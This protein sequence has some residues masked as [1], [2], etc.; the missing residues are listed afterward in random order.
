M[1]CV[2]FSLNK[3]FHV[4]FLEPSSSLIFITAKA[5]TETIQITEYTQYTTEDETNLYSRKIDR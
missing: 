3:Y 4:F 1:Y 5:Y 2:L